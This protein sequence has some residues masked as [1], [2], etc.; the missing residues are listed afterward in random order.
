MDSEKG[1]AY[2]FSKTNIYTNRIYQQLSIERKF[3][4]LDITRE[5]TSTN[6]KGKKKIANKKTF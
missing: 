2:V 6:Q 5:K 3:E 1:L 4:L